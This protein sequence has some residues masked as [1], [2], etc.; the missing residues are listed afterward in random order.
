MANERGAGP[1]GA[2]SGP[3]AATLR[4]ALIGERSDAVLAHRAIPLALARAAE[5]RGLRI[6]P[7][8]LA[9][10]DPA[11]QAAAASCDGLWCVPG[12]P[13][14]SMDGALQ[15]IR[16]V[17]ERGLPF[18]GTCGG[19]Q[20]ALIEYARDVLGWSDAEHAET[21]PAR[22]APSLRRSPARWSSSGAACASRPD[23][24]SPAPTVPTRPRRAITATMA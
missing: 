10:D 7:V 23:R 21:A 24:S 16:G 5:G 8:W 6:E 12:S 18:L 9:T 22:R 1:G 17:R 3:E 13:Y 4:I 19:F 20:H 2:A 14:R 15:A 11:L